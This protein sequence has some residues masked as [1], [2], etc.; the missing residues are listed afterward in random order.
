MNGEE[1]ITCRVMIS[2][3]ILQFKDALTKIS[4]ITVI[5][6][7]NESNA[8]RCRTAGNRFIDKSSSACGSAHQK[9]TPLMKN[10]IMGILSGFL[11]KKIVS[12]PNT[13]LKPQ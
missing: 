13:P 12:A 11:N 5:R 6:E 8:L 3:E 1:T 9:M 2:R 10:N 7:K 4:V